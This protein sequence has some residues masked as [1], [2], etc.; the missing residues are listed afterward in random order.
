MSSPVE[1]SR[2]DAEYENKMTLF[3]SD[4]N[5]GRGDA[6]ACHHVAEFLSVVKNDYFRAAQVYKDNCEV[7]KYA[8]SCFNLGRLH[9]KSFNA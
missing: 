1:F 7:K 8:A 6:P 2:V 9:R 4:C 5:D 3:E